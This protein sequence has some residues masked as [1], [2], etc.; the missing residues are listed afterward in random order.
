MNYAKLANEARVV[1]GEKELYSPMEMDL[2][3]YQLDPDL[4]PDVNWQDRNSAQDFFP[5]DL[6]CKCTGRW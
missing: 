5:A 6:L 1:S 3:Q 2:I 4:Y